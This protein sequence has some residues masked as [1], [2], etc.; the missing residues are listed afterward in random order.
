MKQWLQDKAKQKVKNKIMNQFNRYEQILLRENE[1]Y[2]LTAITDLEEIRQKHFA[3]SMN[4]LTHYDIPN[5]SRVL[6]IGSGGGFPG[7]PLKI[8]RPDIYLTLL[9][10][11][12]KKCGF[13]K[14]L[15]GELKLDL[16]VTCARAEEAAHDAALREQF[17]LVV[18]RAVA[19]LPMLCELCL[20][21]VEVGGMFVAYKGTL[22]KTEQELADAAGA[23]DACGAQFVS[24]CPVASSAMGE[25]TLVMIKKVKPTPEEYP[26]KNSA[27][28]K[29]A[30]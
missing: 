26:R 25:R 7:V 23:I 29:K 27:I 19:A 2:N 15:A 6:D 24:L 17:D 11:S 4:I 9:E 5:E 8:V 16:Q 28:Q 10:S 13:L 1:K 22:E 3:D 21:F 20:P 30:L 18:S 12:T 14:L